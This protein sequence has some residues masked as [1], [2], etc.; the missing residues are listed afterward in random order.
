MPT[1]ERPPFTAKE[2]PHEFYGHDESAGPRREAA[3]GVAGEE[4][5]G[6]E[7]GQVNEEGGRG[8]VAPSA[9]ARASR[10]REGKRSVQGG[11]RSE[12][13]TFDWKTEGQEGQE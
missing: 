10:H 11:D 8:K 9:V 3:T 12:G 1:G 7:G 2:M 6:P 5:E 13:C 4:R